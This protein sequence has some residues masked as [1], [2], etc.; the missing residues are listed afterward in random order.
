MNLEKYS[1]EELVKLVSHNS[2]IHNELKRRNILR[3]KNIT[4]EIGEYFIVKL[5]NNT[6]KFPQLFLPPPGVKNIDVISRKGD[7]YSIKTITSRKGTT[8]SF[9]DPDSIEKN[10]KKFEFLIICVLDDW[11]NLDLVLELTWADFFKFKRFNSRMNN[12]QINLTNKLVAAVKVIVDTK[13]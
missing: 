10:E 4:G 11:N 13:I 3:T 5:Y 8:G 2:E 6:P 1:D 7:R 12:Y 9:W